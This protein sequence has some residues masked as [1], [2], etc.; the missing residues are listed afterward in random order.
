M[1]EHIRDFATDEFYGGKIDPTCPRDGSPF[2][3]TQRTKIIDEYGT[4]ENFWTVVTDLSYGLTVPRPGE[5]RKVYVYTDDK[6]QALTE[7]DKDSLI[8]RLTSQVNSQTVPVPNG[9]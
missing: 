4:R 5:H 9:A 8:A 3:A 6:E 1:S 2:Y 7:G